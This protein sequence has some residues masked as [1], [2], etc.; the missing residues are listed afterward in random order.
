MI[1]VS[2]TGLVY[3]AR[4]TSNSSGDPSAASQMAG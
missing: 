2:V 4:C 1:W 3:A